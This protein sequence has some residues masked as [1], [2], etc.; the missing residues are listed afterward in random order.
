[1]AEPTG[2][3]EK[4]AEAQLASEEIL[5]YSRHLILPEVGFEGQLKLKRA[6]V[7]LVGVGGLGSPVGLYLAAAGVGRLGVADFDVVEPGNL[8]RQ[9][10][11]AAGDVG[12]LKLDS[13]AEAI[14]DLNPGVAVD[15]HETALTS[16]N[17][18]EILAGYDVVVDG[19]DNF[20]T[21]Y[22]VN[23]AC[24]LLGKPDVYGSV[25]RFEGQAAVFALPGGPCYRC[26]YP[27]PPPPGA[28]PSCAEA[29]IL[30]VLPGLIGMIMA[31]ETVKLILGAGA[32]LA[33]RLLL[34]DA[35]AM[36]FREVR[37]KRN[38]GCPVCG[39]NPAVRELI[40]YQAFCG[41]G[42]PDDQPH[43]IGDLEMDVLELNARLERGESVTLVDVREP[44]E[45]QI[46][47]LPGAVL[48]PLKQLP[49]RL[50]ELDPSAELVAY[51]KT[52]RRS[53]KAAALLAGAGFRRARSLKGGIAAWSG[54]IDPA[55]PRY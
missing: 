32:P 38:P 31:T 51:C 20:P 9:I 42:K 34:Y 12:R 37:L 8:H 23:D 15:R 22:L 28:V 14:R 17:A 54:T 16:R 13:A 39:G 10:M 46:C 18:M 4:P 50:G 36:R 29:G 55:M 26:L 3:T 5:R 7:L 48:I 35:L 6:K 11:H 52:G 44:H 49:G 41:L 27:E 33:G 25:Y 19:S 43:V 1:M 53:A 45:Y 40:D 47:R 21:R 24:V 30:G 2:S